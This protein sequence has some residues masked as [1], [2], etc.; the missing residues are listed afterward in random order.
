M[1]KVVKHLN[2]RQIIIERDGDYFLISE[3]KE[4]IEPKETFVFPS[5]AE[6]NVT[7]WIEVGG[8]IG[9]GLDRY[10]QSVLESGKIVAPWTYGSDDLPW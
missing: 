6:G 1:I 5:D 4:N 7:E 3:S 10:L 9:V 8:E 2:H